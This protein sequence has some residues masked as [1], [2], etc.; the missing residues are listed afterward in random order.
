M[1]SFVLAFLFLLSCAINSFAQGTGW[2]LADTNLPYFPYDIS[3]Y[4]VLDT[5]N[6]VVR[7][8]ATYPYSNVMQGDV[9]AEDR[10][11]LQIGRIFNKFHSENLNLMERRKSFKEKVSVRTRQYYLPFLVYDNKQEG[12]LEVVNRIP[13]ASNNVAYCYMEKE[14][15]INWV[16]DDKTDTLCGY[17]CYHAA[18]TFGGRSWDVWFTLDVP[19][20]Y[21]PWKLGGLPGLILKAEDADSLF[22][23]EMTEMVQVS[24][25]ITR[26]NWNYVKISKKKWL[27]YEEAIHKSPYDYFT[28]GGTYDI[29]IG[30][31][32]EKMTPSW[33]IPYYPMEK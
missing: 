17:S 31:T 6:L 32:N 1:K 28:K 30:A 21:G 3:D 13:F 9:Q 2:G 12:N 25:P 22:R 7:Y 23:F 26:P 15:S 18:S 5:T 11:V 33:T 20:P 24:E 10:M 19:Y 4:Q 8:K 14:A 29:F 27:K 16:I